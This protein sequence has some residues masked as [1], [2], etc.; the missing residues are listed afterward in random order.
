M[1]LFEFGSFST[2]DETQ[3]LT[4]IKVFILWIK[5]CVDRER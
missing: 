4:G 5:M 3:F 2:L 1:G